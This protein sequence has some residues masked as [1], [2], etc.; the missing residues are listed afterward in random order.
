MP[1]MFNHQNIVNGKNIVANCQNNYDQ[2]QKELSFHPSKDPFTTL[3]EKISL[4]FYFSIQTCNSHN[5]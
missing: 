5:L 4:S 1:H 2:L 3:D